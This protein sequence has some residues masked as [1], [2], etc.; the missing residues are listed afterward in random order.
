MPLRS[1]KQ[2][3]LAAAGLALLAVGTPVLLGMSG[4]LSGNVAATVFGATFSGVVTLA[5]AYIMRPQGN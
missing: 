2:R 4:I 1:R 5:A 3:W